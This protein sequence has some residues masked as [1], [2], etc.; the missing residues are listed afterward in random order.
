[1]EKK[2]KLTQEEI[3][4]KVRSKLDDIRE[5]LV[6]LENDE[7]EDWKLLEC[8]LRHPPYKTKEEDLIVRK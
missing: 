6:T 7:V 2:K 8:C 1:M 5:E 4:E 3:D